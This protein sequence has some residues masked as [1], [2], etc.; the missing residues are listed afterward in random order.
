MLITW[1]LVD[2]IPARERAL[3]GVLRPFIRS[4][5]AGRGGQFSGFEDWM[6]L[7]SNRFYCGYV[8]NVA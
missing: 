6:I 7:A 2:I 8:S 5:P 4:D 3:D 1:R